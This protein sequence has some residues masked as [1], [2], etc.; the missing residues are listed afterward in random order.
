MSEPW[1]VGKVGQADGQERW[2]DSERGLEVE[3][4]MRKIG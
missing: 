3:T 4:E 1:R 2:G